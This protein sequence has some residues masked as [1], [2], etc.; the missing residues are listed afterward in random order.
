MNYFKKMIAIGL[1]AVMLSGNCMAENVDKTEDVFVDSGETE[2]TERLK[3][4]ID[5]TVTLSFDS[6]ATT[7]YSWTGFVLGGESIELDS[8]DGVYIADDNPEMLDG[9]GGE[10]VFTLIPQKEGRSILSFTYGRSWE[11]SME[12]ETLILADVDAELNI[13]TMDV[14]ESSP[15]QGIVTAVDSEEHSVTLESETA[16]EIV[17]VFEE[18]LELPVE[19]EEVCIYTDGTMTMSIPAIVNVLAWKTI[20]NEYAREEEMPDA[21]MRTDA[22]DVDLLK[23]MLIGAAAAFLYLMHA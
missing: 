21:A 13:S 12:D 19:E 10:T 17:A 7:G 1:A 4:V 18:N 15:I 5:K 11:D 23:Y 14:T 16:G 8:M 22:A 2:L 6:N 20:P 9:V 3:S